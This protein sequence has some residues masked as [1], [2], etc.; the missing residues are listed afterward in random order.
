M[1]PQLHPQPDVYY[2]S[3][4]VFVQGDQAALLGQYGKDEFLSMRFV[5]EDGRWKITDFA[6]SDK[7]YP[8]ESVYA[9]VPPPR[10]SLR[11]RGGAVAE[12]RA[13]IR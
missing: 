3:S 4:R 5:K 1:G 12:R 8:A 9:M 6:F 13:G 10:G 11:A 2:T 7:A